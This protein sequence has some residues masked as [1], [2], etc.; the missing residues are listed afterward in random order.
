VRGSKIKG[1]AQKSM[2]P[3]RALAQQSKM[4]LFKFGFKKGIGEIEAEEQ[5]QRQVEK[6]REKDLADKEA[7]AQAATDAPPKR[8]S[9]RPP[10]VHKAKLK[11]KQ[12]TGRKLTK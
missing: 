8:K 5:Q 11:G 3:R 6:A 2:S 4:A 1:L 9:G 7:A 12:A 10:L